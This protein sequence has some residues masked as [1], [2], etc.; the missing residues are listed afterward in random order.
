MKIPKFSRRK[1]AGN[2]LEA[3][4]TPERPNLGQ[5][6]KSVDGGSR[7][8]LFGFSGGKKAQDVQESHLYDRYE[9]FDSIYFANPLVGAVHPTTLAT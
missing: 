4:V 6:N 7:L 5:G 2:E 9:N 8:S 1:S 3:T